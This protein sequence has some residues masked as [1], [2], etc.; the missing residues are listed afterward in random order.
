MRQNV[1]EYAISRKKN[2]KN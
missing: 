1:S 2:I